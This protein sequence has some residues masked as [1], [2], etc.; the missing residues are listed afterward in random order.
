MVRIS[1]FLKL[2]LLCCTLLALAGFL[3]PNGIISIAAISLKP[4]LIAAFLVLSVALLATRKIWAGCFAL[5]LSALGVY[6]LAPHYQSSPSVT[7]PDLTIV[8]ANVWRRTIAFE[9]ALAVAD[10]VGAN[11]LVIGEWPESVS[12]PHGWFE[13][14]PEA[15][16]PFSRDHPRS[17]LA[18]LLMALGLWC[19]VAH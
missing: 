5:T 16:S 2:A 17:R 7:A 14:C 12:V 18:D 15:R 8:W 4:S 10:E 19:P 9:R 11:Y 3:N 13:T 1:A 6:S